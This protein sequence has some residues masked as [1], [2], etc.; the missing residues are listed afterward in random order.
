MVK[1]YS[2]YPGRRLGVLNVECSYILLQF[3][4]TSGNSRKYLK[5]PSSASPKFTASGTTLNYN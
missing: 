3:Q 5:Y 4:K 1:R 2:S